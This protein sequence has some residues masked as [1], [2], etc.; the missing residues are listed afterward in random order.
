MI[1]RFHDFLNL[2]FGGF[3]QYDPTVRQQGSSKALQNSRERSLAAWQWHRQLREWT[4]VQLRKWV[5][6]ERGRD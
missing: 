1:R 3:L 5:D 4:E 6:A 2:V